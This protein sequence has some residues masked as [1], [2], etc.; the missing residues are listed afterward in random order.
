[1]FKYS[2]QLEFI[3]INDVNI[4]FTDS[5][6][7][8]AKQFAKDPPFPPDLRYYILQMLKFLCVFRSIS[9]FSLLFYCS[10]YLCASITLHSVLTNTDVK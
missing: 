7:V 3:L 1:M 4:I 10:I 6:L 5:Y 8:I 2:T 9:V